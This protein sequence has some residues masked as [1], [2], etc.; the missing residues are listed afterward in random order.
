MGVRFEL[1][2]WALP[3]KARVAKKKALQSW[4]KLKP[5]PETDDTMFKKIIDYVEAK[6]KTYEWQKDGGQF[7]PRATAML[8]QERWND[9]EV[10][11][12][13]GESPFGPY[14]AELAPR[15]EA[16]SVWNRMGFKDESDYLR[17]YNCS[18]EGFLKEVEENP[19]KWIRI[20]KTMAKDGLLA[21][22]PESFR[23]K[24]RE[25]ITRG[26]DAQSA[27]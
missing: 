23:V 7:V 19:N 13:S 25:A 20:G 17:A 24:M 18:V 22:W 3:E 5:D 4:E 27:A 8:N 9:E 11:S 15:K 26:L 1:F 6:K 12:P 2:W 14:D 16:F 21:K 10:K